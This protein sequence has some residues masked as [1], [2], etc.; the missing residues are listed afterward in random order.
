ML[1]IIS[2]TNKHEQ[3]MNHSKRVNILRGF[4]SIGEFDGRM[5]FSPM[6][7]EPQINSRRNTK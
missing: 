3:N 4:V 7:K 5:L 6:I 2:K 1:N